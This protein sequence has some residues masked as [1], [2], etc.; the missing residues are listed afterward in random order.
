MIA[1]TT[2]TQAISIN[3]ATTPRPI[4][5]RLMIFVE[6]CMVPPSLLHAAGRLPVAGSDTMQNSYRAATLSDRST[7]GSRGHIDLSDCGTALRRAPSSGLTSRSDA[8][9]DGDRS[10]VRRVIAEV[11]LDEGPEA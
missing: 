3:T 11:I 1:G 5:R 8:L 10:G 4:P 6:I 9:G 2:Q 7:A